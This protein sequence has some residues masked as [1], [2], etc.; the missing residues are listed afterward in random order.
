MKVLIAVEDIVFGEAISNYVIQHDW[1]EMPSFKIINVVA[2]LKYIIP[3]VTGVSDTRYIDVLEEKKRHGKSVVLNVGTALR[4]AFPHAPLEE[5][6]IDG[7]PKS[8]ILDVADQWQADLIVMGSHSRSDLGRLFLGSVSLA[9]LSHAG[10]SV[11]IVRTGNKCSKNLE[12]DG[13]ASN[14]VQMAKGSR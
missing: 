4:R 8:K 5:V 10:C 2:P 7:D 11:A 6:V 12:E 9:V 13:V 3:P 1:K 14:A